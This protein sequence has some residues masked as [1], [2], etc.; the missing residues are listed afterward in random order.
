MKRVIEKNRNCYIY[1]TFQSEE[2]AKEFINQTID[3]DKIIH[4]SKLRKLE[5]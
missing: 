1:K 4:E 3:K 5:V 2:A